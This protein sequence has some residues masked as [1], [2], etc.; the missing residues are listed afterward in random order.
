M[1][2]LS[3]Q[4]YYLDFELWVRIFFFSFYFFMGKNFKVKKIFKGFILSNYKND[5]CLC[6]NLTSTENIKEAHT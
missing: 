5:M 1:A 3:Q 2:F 6:K 4:M